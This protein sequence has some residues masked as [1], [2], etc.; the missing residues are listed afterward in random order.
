MGL[1]TGTSYL[2]KRTG[3][4]GLSVQLDGSNYLKCSELYNELIK[5]RVSINNSSMI[6]YFKQNS[7]KNIKL[8]LF[9]C[10][11]AGN[12]YCYLGSNHDYSSE[13]R[14]YE[15]YSNMTVPIDALLNILRRRNWQVKHKHLYLKGEDLWEIL[16]IFNKKHYT[17]N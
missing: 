17:M 3:E 4:F 8:T 5:Y 13:P 11:G 7:F 12:N 6:N 1:I 15:R 2:P 14:Y 16:E 10:N 9:A